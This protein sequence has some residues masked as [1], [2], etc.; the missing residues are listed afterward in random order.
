MQLLVRY[1]WW[2]IAL[3]AAVALL[4]NALM[5]IH[6]D[7]A[8][9]W[10]WSQNLA[11]GYFD[12]PPMVAYVIWLTTWFSDQVFWLRLGAVLCNLV[13]LWFFYLLVRGLYNNSNIARLA[14]LLLA[15]L[16]LLHINA[17][18]ITPDAPLAAFWSIGLFAGWRALAHNHP[19]YWYLTG[20]AIG[21]MVASKLIAAFF[22]LPFCL[23]LLCYKR[24]LVAH[25]HVWLAGLL[26]L[27]PALGMLYWNSHNNWLNFAYQFTHA[28][29]END[30]PNPGAFAAHLGGYILIVTPVL[31]GVS[32]WGLYRRWQQRHLFAAGEGFL[33][34]F[35]TIIFAFFVYKSTQ[36]HILLN[37]NSPI[38]FSLLPLAARDLYTSA[39]PR[40]VWACILTALLLVLLVRIP[41]LIGINY[42]PLR[43]TFALEQGIRTF[44]STLQPGEVLCSDYHT[45]A[46][47]LRYY[48]GHQ[49]PVVVRFATRP[50]QYDLWSDPQPAFCQALVY[51]NSIRDYHRRDCAAIEQHQSFTVAVSDSYQ[52]AFQT[53]Y[54]DL[55]PWN[56][57]HQQA[58][59]EL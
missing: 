22:I 49:H 4:Y 10:L 40:L 39:K 36:S 8:Y 27:L 34:L 42:S 52:P 30:F 56:E 9:Y 3:F 24:S 26:S 7:E 18:A 5:P 1:C 19:G 20:L 38:V 29:A 54:C 12:H 6:Y 50:S 17:T 23:Y 32:L 59:E 47:T 35:T 15:A 57:R 53:F 28:T 33:L 16:P 31:L 43:H 13:A 21:C 14:T 58:Q 37:W 25:R 48:L 45:T 2:L 51:R 41:W 55:T 46:A 11:W 44:A